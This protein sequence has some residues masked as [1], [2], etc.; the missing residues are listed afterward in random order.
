MENYLLTED[1]FKVVLSMRKFG[2]FASFKI[3]KRPTKQQP[4]GELVKVVAEIRQLMRS[5]QE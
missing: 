1:E 3:E 2:P 4:E 5:I